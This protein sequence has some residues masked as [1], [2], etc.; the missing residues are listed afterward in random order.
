MARKTSTK[1]KDE[2]AAPAR[3]TRGVVAEKEKDG[4]SSPTFISKERRSQYE[5]LPA[6]KTKGLKPYTSNGD[7]VALAVRG[8]D[9]DAMLQLAVD[10]GIEPEKLTKLEALNNGQVK[11]GV[12]NMLRARIK[13]GEKVKINGRIIAAL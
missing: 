11:M 1:T 6:D 7:T 3:T 10:N 9:R 2:G 8:M 4:E 12:S 13:K 5:R